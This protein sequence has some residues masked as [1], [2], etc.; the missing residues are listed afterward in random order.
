MSWTT[1][2]EIGK[3]K[4]ATRKAKCNVR[5]DLS[6]GVKYIFP[7]GWRIDAKHHAERSID[8]IAGWLDM[9]WVIRMASYSKT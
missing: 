8:A 2:K 9:L 1:F 6:D 7:D 3:L 5:L 4:E